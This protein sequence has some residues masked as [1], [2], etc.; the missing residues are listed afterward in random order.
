MLAWAAFGDQWELNHKVV[1]DGA[2]ELIIVPNDA[3]TL[4]VATDI[5]TAWQQWQSLYDNNQY[6]TAVRKV[7]DFYFLQN[8]WQFIPGELQVKN[9]TGYLNPGELIAAAKGA[10]G[11]AAWNV[12]P[13]TAP[14]F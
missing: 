9:V 3:I 12:E 14:L 8:G 1:F 5:Y 11:L 6:D 10:E 13:G 2:N 4:D 7:L